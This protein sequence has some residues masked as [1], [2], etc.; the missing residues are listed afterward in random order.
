MQ[1]THWLI[2]NNRKKLKSD[3]GENDGASSSVNYSLGETRDSSTSWRRC[4]F[5]CRR[6][7]GSH[8]PAR[9]GFIYQHERDTKRPWIHRENGEKGPSYRIV[10]FRFVNCAA[11]DIEIFSTRFTRLFDR[12]ARGFLWPDT[13]LRKSWKQRHVHLV[14]RKFRPSCLSFA[15]QSG[16]L[17]Q[18]PSK[19]RRLSWNWD[20]NNC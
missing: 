5:N 12:R 1:L 18:R 9:L 13:W 10:S 17:L 16:Q 11:L 7:R 20:N 8:G 2:G 6:P 3:T 15:S 4:R 14:S 19:V